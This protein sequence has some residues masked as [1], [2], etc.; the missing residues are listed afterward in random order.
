MTVGMISIA[1]SDPEDPKSIEQWL[2][3]GIYNT[4]TDSFNTH[5]QVYIEGLDN[6]NTNTTYAEE[7]NNA[8]WIPELL[9]YMPYIIF[10]NMFSIFYLEIICMTK[11]TAKK[12]END[13]KIGHSINFFITAFY[14]LIFAMLLALPS[15]NFGK[16]YATACILT[17]TAN[18]D[19]TDVRLLSY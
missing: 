6:T 8:S 18:T 12:E 4:T 5:N 3:G 9:N 16:L 13:K 19:C 17:D 15:L 11:K 10:T 2:I 7:Q 1:A 14:I